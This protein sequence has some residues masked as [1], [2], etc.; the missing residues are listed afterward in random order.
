MKCKTMMVLLALFFVGTASAALQDGLVGYYTFDGN[1]D[2][3]SSSANVNNGVAVGSPGYVS[4][5][6]FGG[7]AVSVGDGTGTSYVSLGMASDYQFGDSTSFTIT[8]WIKMP[9]SQASDPGFIGNK[10]WSSSGGNTG[11]VQVV[12]AGDDI[13]ANIADGSTRADTSLID[14]DHDAYWDGQGKDADD[15][16]RWSFVAMTVNRTTN[17]LTNYVM[18]GWVVNQWDDGSTPTTADITGIGSVDS[19]YALNIGQDGDG[20][21]YDND[22]YPELLATIDDMGIWRR[23]LTT[24]EIWGIYDAGRNQGM[25]LGETIPEPM[26]LSLLGLGGLALLRRRRA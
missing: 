4:S 17:T 9:G 6:L 3:T 25:T 22:A 13:K 24:D 16:I 12:G 2:D 18:D 7:S 15:P 20:A 14:Y 23:A 5:S 19:G 11:F 21:G 1:L 10:D 26:T 8:Y